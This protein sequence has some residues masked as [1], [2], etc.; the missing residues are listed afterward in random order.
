MAKAET[1]DDIVS[2]IVDSYEE[3]LT[4]AVNKATNEAKED[5]YEKSI[6]LLHKYYYGYRKPK[7]YKRTDSLRK[8][9]IPLIHVLKSGDGLACEVGVKYDPKKLDG[10]YK[11]GS[12]KYG[13]I[14]DE[15]GHITK[16]GQPDS[17]WVLNNFLEGL[18]P[19]NVDELKKNG[20]YVLMQAHEGSGD[21]LYFSKATQEHYMRR[22]LRDYYKD[23]MD[24]R[25]QTYMI[26]YAMNKIGR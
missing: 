1:L 23:V 19:W 25:I 22:M 16:W 13:A 3:A 20:N 7:Q 12:E 18:H 15:D 11:S 10:A 14:K 9:F 21:G 5:I 4:F 26:E 24:P 2:E 17:E 6:D 8:S